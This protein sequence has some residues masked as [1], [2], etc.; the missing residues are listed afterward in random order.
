V[1]AG[2]RKQVATA[3]WL[4][5]KEAKRV[6]DLP[7]HLNV[8][9]TDRI[10]RLYNMLRKELDDFFSDIRPLEDFRGLIVNGRFDREMYAE[11]GQIA[12]IY[13]VNIALTLG[14]R[15]K[16][17]QAVT[18][19]DAAVNAC[20]ADDVVAR[21]KAFKAR[22]K[23]KAALRWYEERSR[24]ETRPSRVSPFLSRWGTNVRSIPR[25]RPPTCRRRGTYASTA[26]PHIWSVS[27]SE[28]AD[29][30]EAPRSHGTMDLSRYTP[31]DPNCR[32]G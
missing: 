27:I 13:G 12:R 16:Y 30:A 28:R 24:Q 18:E 10:G 32:L 15:E 6:S 29:S 25:G 5:L 21:R 4:R 23:A 3:P 20:A 7:L 9:P 19:A 14:K 22:N 31:A 17:R 26:A 1:I 8:S 2:V 11:A